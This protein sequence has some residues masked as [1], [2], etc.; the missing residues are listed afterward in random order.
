MEGGEEAGVQA[1]DSWL[2]KLGCL[3]RMHRDI[4]CQWHHS[5]ME[6]NTNIP[7]PPDTFNNPWAHKISDFPANYKLFAVERQVQ[8]DNLPRKDYYLYGMSLLSSIHVTS[9]TAPFRREIQV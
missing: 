5:S 9:L 2:W 6:A 3:V 4:G 1:R 7:L 8:G